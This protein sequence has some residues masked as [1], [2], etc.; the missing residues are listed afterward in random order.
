MTSPGVRDRLRRIVDRGG[1]V[2]VVDPRRTETAKLA[3]EYVGIR[4]GGDPYLLLGMLHT[5]FE[6]HLA[7]PGEHL[8]GLDEVEELAALWSP[9]RAAPL[10]GVDVGTIEHLARDFATARKAVAYGRVGV[11]QQQT[12]TLTHWL[13]VVLNAITG[14]LDRVGGAMFTTPPVDVALGMRLAKLA[15]GGGHGS[16]TQRTT[17]FPEMNG[18]LPVAGLAREI[19]TPGAGQVRGMLVIAGNPV[20]STPGGATLDAAMEQLDFCVAV[21]LYVTETSRHADVILPPVSQLERGDLDIVMPAVAVR[22]HIRYS[23]PAV[24]KQGREDWEI[25][26]GLIGRLGRGRIGRAKARIFGVGG[27]LASPERMLDG[28]FAAGPYGVL[29]KGPKG[30]TVRKVKQASH[31][32]DLGPL[33][34][35][36]PGVLSTKTKRVQLAPPSFIEGAAELERHEADR[37]AAAAEGYDLVLIGRRQLHNNNS[38]MHNSKRLTKGRDRCTALLHPDDATARGLSDGEPVL[39]TSRMGSIQVPVEISDEIR[40]GVVSIPHGFGHQRAGVGWTHAASLPGASIND[41]TDPELVDALT[42]NAAFNAVPVRVELAATGDE[43]LPLE[44]EAV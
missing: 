36:L 12:G 1:R 6:E 8:D 5:I 19:T 44:A 42:G 11:C 31:G 24:P 33:E 10:A 34:P 43:P 25:V 17:G 37:A 32:I 28:L 35:R 41:I 15:G 13:I 21:D 27:K 38:W 26:N 40:P 22:N 23:P 18:E 9:Q 29:R 30:L 14:N 16:F 7:R 20:L 3:T 2:V 4:P 39:V